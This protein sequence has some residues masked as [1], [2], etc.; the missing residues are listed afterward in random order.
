MEKRAGVYEIEIVGY[1]YYGSSINI[2]AR[3]QNHI[4][5][6]RSGKHRNQRLQ[7][8]FD[9]Y[10]EDAIAFKILVICDEESVLD[11][12][13]KYLDENIGNNN[14]LN[15]CKNA[16]APMAGIKFSDEHKKKMSESQVRNKYIF[17]Y[18][19]GKI[20]SF[21]SLKLAG[22]KFGVR[23]SIVSRW[24]K[25]KDL[26]RNHGI[27]QSSNIIKAEKI[28]DEHIILLPWQYKQEPWQVAG[29]TSKTKYYKEKRNEIKT[30]NWQIVS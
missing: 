9:K 22:D 17:Y 26:G 30:R 20:E 21:D 14:C 4:A 18:D 10:G 13:Q 28:G 6:L 24:F 12:E 25:R 5:K 27:L 23:S 15:F 29:A 1:K 2:Y 11:E 7:R 3:K 16:S 19:C 8:C